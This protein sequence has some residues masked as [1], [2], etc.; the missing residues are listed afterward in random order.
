MTEENP[1]GMTPSPLRTLS[2]NWLVAAFLLLAAGIGAL[3][4]SAISAYETAVLRDR[5]RELQAI[6]ELKIEFI[7]L[8]LDERR[9]D[10]IVQA[11]RLMMAHALVPRAGSAG[12]YGPDDV[13]GQLE[14]IRQAYQYKAVTLLDRDGNIRFGTGPLSD[15]GRRAT[16]AAAKA[17]M[18]GRQVQ[19]VRAYRPE[20][21][22]RHHIDIDIAAPVADSRL[23][24]APIVGALAFHLDSQL[25]LDP[26]LRRWPAPGGSGESFLFERAG[27]ALVYLTSLRHAE[28]ATMRRR[29]TEP[30]LPAAMAAKGSQGGVGGI[31]Y[32]GVPV[33]AAVGRVPDMPW[34]VVAKLD[35]AEILAP[36][37]R[38]ALWSGSLSALL[39][40][41]LGLAMFSWW[42]R[43]QGELAMAKL[44]ASRDALRASEARFRKLIENGW[45]FHI[46]FDRGMRI[47]YSSPSI[48]HHLGR[49]LL[50]ESIS[51]GTA[52]VHPEDVAHVEDVRLKALAAPGIP[53]RVEHRLKGR[54]QS[55]LKVEAYFV[56]QFDDPDI[57]AL[58]YT[59][60][61]ITERLEAERSLRESEERYR[62][63]FENSPLPMWIYDSETL[64]FI[65]VNRTAVAQYGYTRDEF[66]AIT[67]R[68]IR[69]PEDMAAMETVAMS[70]QRPQG[71]IWTHRRKD[72]SRIKVAIW[73]RDVPFSD[74]SARMVLAENVTARV[75]AEAALV[76]SEARLHTIFESVP[77][78]IAIAD[79]QG[80]YAM[81]NPA[82]CRMLG[83]SEEELLGRTYTEFTHNEEVQTNLDLT[84]LVLSGTSDTATMEKRYARKDGSLFWVLLTVGR[85]RDSRGEPLG[86]VG[87]VQDITERR[88]AEAARLEFVR[89]QRDTLVREVHHRIKN[90]L[91]GLAGLLN[92]HRR[93]HPDQEDALGTVSAQINAIS[94]IHGLQGREASGEVHLFKL[95]R[96]IATFL[97]HRAA[98][99]FTNAGNPACH[100]CA[101][102]VVDE[103]S[104]P[105]ALVINELV[106]NAIKHQ[107]GSPD[108]P[109]APVR[110]DCFCNG[111]RVVVTVRNPGCLPVDF[112]F[113]A[114]SALGTGLTLVRSL[115]SPEGAAL[116]ICA[117]DGMVESRLTLAPPVISAK[118]AD[119]VASLR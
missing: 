84:A 43:G 114:G 2:G 87:I 10:A 80:R 74:R 28:A 96:E 89:Q 53:Q 54:E 9:A 13:R 45:D 52:L 110:I 86:T 99:E 69:P 62:F 70:S 101:W 82:Q 65:E 85:V 26:L 19:L 20:E 24:G 81:V 95:L 29:I 16:V 6:A 79:R 118:A 1:R 42:R 91:Q 88:E 104:V 92:Q 115:L 119:Q 66:L 77:V 27:E 64:A 57:G 98:L 60:R 49:N 111:E 67:L 103:E 21:D 108:G 73:S 15:F 32:R 48:S 58:T 102:R 44:D 18:A 46:L 3:W 30:A 34:Y 72:G 117:A 59:G 76:E 8:W 75:E 100:G 112:D 33:L 93:Q 50:G 35:R 105:V 17:A 56:S 14:A 11:G 94:V 12:S 39:V 68:D 23:P 109:P 22:G 5:G 106:T 36:V 97:G 7:R 25:H 38:E 41:A 71:C 47:V 37:R 4:Y 78:G 63:L 51:S 83:Y 90:H 107:V 116:S 40:L 61:N 31:D 113:A 55:W